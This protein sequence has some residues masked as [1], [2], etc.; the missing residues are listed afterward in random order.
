MDSED[1]PRHDSKSAR[2]PDTDMARVQ[3]YRVATVPQDLLRRDIV[4]NASAQYIKRVLH[5]VG[6]TLA[7]LFHILALQIQSSS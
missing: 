2:T 7:L 5:H 1:G 3:T 6:T 4:I